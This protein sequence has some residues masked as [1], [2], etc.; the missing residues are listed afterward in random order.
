LGTAGSRRAGAHPLETPLLEL[1]EAIAKEQT[2]ATLESMLCRWNGC[3]VS[4][5]Y[6]EPPPVASQDPFDEL[7][8]DN[9]DWCYILDPVAHFQHRSWRQL[10]RAAVE[11][12]GAAGPTSPAEHRADRDRELY[13]TLRS[14]LLRLK[15]F[16]RQPGQTGFHPLLQSVDILD[17]L[18]GTFAVNDATF[19]ID[20]PLREYLVRVGAHTP[21]ALQQQVSGCLQ[22]LLRLI[23]ERHPSGDIGA[24]GEGLYPLHACINHS[25]TPNAKQV[26][27]HVDGRM[28]IRALRDI[29]PGEPLTISYIRELQDRTKRQQEL[30]T[31]FGFSCAC[32][33]CRLAADAPIPSSSG[34]S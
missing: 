1:E 24:H 31:T 25:C 20:H 15:V 19:E 2:T 30:L 9:P 26:P 22:P 14:A 8:F 18:M 27:G 28:I 32:S 11:D 4:L 29:Q 33:A 17:Y 10:R 21:P 5:T 3:L 16:F 12:E 13:T 34:S 23:N 6:P 7:I